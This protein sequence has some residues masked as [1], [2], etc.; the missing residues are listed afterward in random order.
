MKG[1]T[2]CLSEEHEFSVQIDGFTGLKLSDNMIWGEAD[3]FIQFFFPAQD[4]E[5]KEKMGAGDGTFQFGYIL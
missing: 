5:L 3:C 4:E 2:F 1:V